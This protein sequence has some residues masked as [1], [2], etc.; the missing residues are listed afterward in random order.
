VSRLLFRPRTVLAAIILASVTAACAESVTAPPSTDAVDTGDSMSAQL[1]TSASTTGAQLNMNMNPGKIRCGQR[2]LFTFA[3]AQNGRPV[4]R[5]RVKVW[6]S[7]KTGKSLTTTLTTDSRGMVSRTLSIP[8][9]NFCY[10]PPVYVNAAVESIGAF[11]QWEII[12]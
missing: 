9:S 6:F 3:V 11:Q 1:S 10:T 5:A 2:A 8:R 7:S 4:N 12:K